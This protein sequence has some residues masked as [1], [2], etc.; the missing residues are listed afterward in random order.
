M[1]IFWEG[2]SNQE[3]IEEMIAVM[4]VLFVFCHMIQRFTWG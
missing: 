1:F 3:Q 4:I 2:Y